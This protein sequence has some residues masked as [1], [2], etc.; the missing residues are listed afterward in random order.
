MTTFEM[1][2]ELL[3]Q[4]EFELLL[5][6]DYTAN[7]TEQ[8]IRLVYQMNDTVESFLVFRKAIFTGTYKKDYEGKLDASYDRDQNRYVLGVRQGDSVITLF[9]QK[10]ELE[11]AEKIKNARQ[12]YEKYGR[13][14]E[15][16]FEHYATGLLDCKEYQEIKSTYQE[17]Q[18]AARQNMKQIQLRGQHL[19]DQ[20]K[21][22]M[23]WTEELL[24]YQRFRKI[25]KGIADRFIE[26][27]TVYSKDY[28]EIVFW[29]GDLF[30]KEL[31]KELDNMEGGL[32][33]AV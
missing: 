12:K 7:T 20:V 33:Y 13:K 1:L 16:L 2:Q 9:Y 5:P 17:E 21:A 4:N 8:D 6:E 14:L 11:V 19:L 3:A 24:K 18:Q 26:K 27:I 22:R 23:D 10:L 15:T 29:F 30:E 25:E 32:P 31:E 28:V